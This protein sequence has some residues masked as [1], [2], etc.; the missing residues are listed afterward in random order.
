M[1]TAIS[2]SH[3]TSG[4]LPHRHDGLVEALLL[5]VHIV[6]VEVDKSVRLIDPLDH[7]ER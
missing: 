2:T 6:G 3:T 7:L 5:D 4:P 1:P